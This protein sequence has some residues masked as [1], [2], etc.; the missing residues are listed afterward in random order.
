MFADRGN[1]N[2]LL[3]KENLGMI[4]NETINFVIC[5]EAGQGIESAGYILARIL[6]K[7][8]YHTFSLPEYMSR[9]KGGCNSNMLK[10]SSQ[11][12]AFYC[13][14]IDVLLQLS[15]CATEHLKT[16]ISQNT[17]IINESKSNFYVIGYVLGLFKFNFDEMSSMMS[18]N[19]AKLYLSEKNKANFETGFNKGLQNQDIE[20]KIKTDEKISS[21]IML[22][23]TEAAAIGCIAGGCDFLTF[24]P[25]SPSTPLSIFLCQN[26]KKFNIITEQ[27]ED[28]IAAINMGLGAAYAGARAIV[29][30]AGGGFALMVEGVSLAGMTETPIVINIA[31]RPA[32]ATGLPTRCAQEDLN[33]ALYAGHGEFPR[34]ILAPSTLENSFEL[35]QKAFNLAQKFQVP[36]FLLTQQDFLDCEYSTE[37]FDIENI[38]NDDY[39]TKSSKDYKRYSLSNGSISPFSIPNYGEGIVCLDSDEHDEDGQITESFEMRTKMM[40]KRLGKTQLIEHEIIAPDFWGEEDFEFLI[41]GWGGTYNVLKSAI[42]G[43]EGFALLHFNW[44]H[45]L[46]EKV[47]EYAQQGCKLA[48]VEQNA[49]GQFKNHLKERF[50]LKFD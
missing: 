1:A 2:F 38:K 39:T 17:I 27:V 21:Q 3:S 19:Y 20:I 14:N 30:S 32:P 10:V 44:L 24:Y 31:Q 50:V 47:L 46:S 15:D 4:F 26:A 41:I 40:N 12:K 36:V 13:R 18:E 11:P 7:M 45:P 49:T 28:E 43:R 16:R 35:A 33:L 9:I 34:I 6:H 48:I 22:S 23:G 8:N 42:E 29:P 37:P 5:G 25:M